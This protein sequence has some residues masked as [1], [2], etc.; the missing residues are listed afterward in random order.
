MKT[1]IARQRSLK[2]SGIRHRLARS[3][4]AVAAV[5]AFAGLFLAMARAQ[6]NGPLVIQWDKSYGAP[7]CDDILYDLV[8]A[9]D[10]SFVLV[11]CYVPYRVPIDQT[12][13]FPRLVRVDAGG[14]QLWDRF[15]EGSLIDVALSALP[16]PGNGLVIAGFTGSA[17]WYGVLDYWATRLD[18]DGQKLWEAAYG[19]SDVDRALWI[20]PASDGG[21]L[22]AG[23]SFSPA[24]GSKTA[25]K[26]GSGDMWV[27]R[28]DANGTQMWDQ[29]FG[30]SSDDEVKVARQTADGGFLLA[31]SSMSLPGT[32]N[33]SSPYLGPSGG[34]LYQGSDMWVVRLD[35][36]GNKIWD[37]SYGGTGRERV[38]DCQTTKDGGFVLAG[39]S[40][41]GPA[42]TPYAGNKTSRLYGGNDYWLVWIDAEGQVLRDRSYG[43]T[44]DDRCLSLL[45]MPDGGWM[46]CGQSKSQP[47]GTKTSPNYGSFDYWLVRI[48][49][50][51]NQLWD[52]SFGG[53][54][55]EGY[56][57][58]T[59]PPDMSVTPLKP[60]ADGGFVLA[61]YS[62]SP[63]SGN[64]TAPLDLGWDYWLVKLGSEP[65]FLRAGPVQSD[66]V[67]LTI[68]GPTNR[69]FTLQGSAD[70]AHWSDLANLTN[71]TGKVEC[72]DQCE[73]GQPARF[74]RAVME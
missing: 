9:D 34:A 5:V 64:K 25:P 14:N 38:F 31:G 8:A 20:E 73:P 37:H 51:G 23:Q 15:Y 59:Y 46:L 30:G 63:P 65:P 11:G 54:G 50:E 45:P 21:Y 66:G 56:D 60:T 43:G 71:L 7:N 52:Q 3:D 12:T 36:S 22:L 49:A 24:S 35:A 6:T 40:S 47:G 68:I 33:K 13:W 72:K 57:L 58:A 55:T 27:V 70:M 26:Y 69:V 32:G 39:Y 28:L 16:M 19:G 29:S 17:A 2:E 61:G 10:G 74:Y 18:S 53:S 41:S 1:P 48:D 44:G 42:A 4:V 67:P 62:K